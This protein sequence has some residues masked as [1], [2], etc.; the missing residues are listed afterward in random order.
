MRRALPALLVL[1]IAAAPPRADA[2]GCGRRPVPTTIVRQL[3]PIGRAPMPTDGAL[4]WL[5]EESFEDGTETS[6]PP[7][8]FAPSLELSLEGGEPRVAIPLP[9]E[10][11]APNLIARRPAQ[12]ISP[13]VYQLVG[14]GAAQTV[15]V[16]RLALPAPRI[17]LRGGGDDGSDLDL[18]G[19]GRAM[20]STSALSATLAAVPSQAAAIVLYEGARPIRAF[21]PA[22]EISVYSP[23]GRCV[24]SLGISIPRGREVTARFVDRW[25]RLGPP[26]AATV[27]R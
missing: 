2:G 19:T 22:A 9:R 10:Q 4:A 14:T 18:F 25:G 5:E 15:E 21:A 16:R 17:S 3:S 1:A 8:A 7:P 12:P 13:G 20:G 6:P 26:S 24:P 23:G 11:L 27:V